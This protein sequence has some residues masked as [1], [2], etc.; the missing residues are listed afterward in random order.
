MTARRE[1][2]RDLPRRQHEGRV[3]GRDHAD[4][5]DR[6]PRR[7][8][9]MSI[10]R[11]REPV[12]RRLGAIGIEAEIL[13]AAERRLRHEADRLAAVPALEHGDIVGAALDTVGD[14]VQQVAAPRAG[15]SRQSGK[16]FCA[17]RA[18]RSTSAALPRATWQIIDPS[19]GVWS[20][21]TRRPRRE[22]SRRRSG[23]RSRRHA[24]DRAAGRGGEVGLQRGIGAV[25]FIVAMLH[26][27][28]DATAGRRATV[29]R[30]WLPGAPGC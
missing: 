12:A 5:A 7:V 9:Q 4:R 2:R 21:N 16:A 17:A 18:A 19:T 27:V 13:R 10:G 14:R 3:P 25:A 11:Q 6:R 15:K 26:V 1:R 20:A 30:G 28:A 29:A 24:A 23:V 22:R 8:V